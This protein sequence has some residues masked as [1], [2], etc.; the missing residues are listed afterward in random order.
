MSGIEQIEVAPDE[1]GSRTDRWFKRRYPGL[2][3]GALEKLLRTGQV[4]IDGKRVKASHRLEAGSVI[5]V[6]PLDEGAKTSVKPAKSPPVK[7][8]PKDVALL[9]RNILHKDDWVIALNK[10]PGLAVQGG[11]GTSRHVDA[12]LDTLRFGSKER[13]R[14]VHRLDKDTSGVLLIART[15][16]A[17]RRLTASFRHKDA[18]KVYWAL[19][20]GVPRPGQGRIDAP[21]GKEG[22]AGEERMTVTDDGKRAVTY[23]K[24]IEPFGK[25]AAWVALMP[26]TGRTHQLRAH[27]VAMGHPVVGDGKYGGKEA[28]LDGRVSKKLHLH[29]RSIEMPHPA[30][31]TLS[32]SA[33]LTSH[34]AE[35]W[36]LFGLD[37]EDDGD[38][39]EEL[40]LD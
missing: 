23:Y 40:E 33:P 32:V 5:R 19:V 29:A 15:A 36:K 17:A 34:M 27:A 1:A 26:V 37:P 25:R 30:G 2:G 4:R 7:V 31:G 38:P 35:A 11:S 21:L 3:H 9:A 18:R 24:V 14:L 12:L 8:D 10:P 13:P 16:E 28:F 6:P 20:V 22:G 39:F